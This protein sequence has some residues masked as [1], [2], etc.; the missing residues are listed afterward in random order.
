[1]SY[2]ERQ[3]LETFEKRQEGRLSRGIQPHWGAGLN[4]TNPNNKSCHSLS[5]C[6][7]S[8]AGPST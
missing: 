8:G 7:E 1:M 3:G 4:N 5:S 2:S 6:D